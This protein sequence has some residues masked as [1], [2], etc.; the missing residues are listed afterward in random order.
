LQPRLLRDIV[1]WL[2]PGGWLLATTGRGAW[3]GTGDNWLGGPATMRWRHGDVGGYRT[4]LGQ[5]GMEVA[6]QQF[7]P[8]GDSGHALFW[9]QRKADSPPSRQHPGAATH[10]R[11]AP[12]STSVGG[13]GAIHRQQAQRGHSP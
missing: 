13:N 1:R 11:V 6:G 5:I 12:V 8:E 3:T 4:W 10:S 2:R 9:P 7:V